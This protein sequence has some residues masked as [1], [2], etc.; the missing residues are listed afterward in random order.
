V[1]PSKARDLFDEA[2]RNHTG[3]PN[4]VRVRQVAG[5]TIK[6]PFTA[7][8]VSASLGYFSEASTQRVENVV[9]R[10]YL[11]EGG[12]RGEI[13]SPHAE[14]KTGVRAHDVTQLA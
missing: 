7:R 5:Q 3:E 13:E 2:C 1:G 8:L 4:D 9:V 11:R 10:K 6:E 12:G 14:V